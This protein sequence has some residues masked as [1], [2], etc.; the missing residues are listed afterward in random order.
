[1]HLGPENLIKNLIGLWTG[2]FK[3]L[4][5]GTG[6]YILPNSTVEAI[7]DECV[8]AGHTTPSAFGA[9]VPNLA[10]QLHYYTAESYT[11]FTTLLAPT[12]LRGRF[13][14]E[15]YYNHLLDLVPTFDDCMALSLDR[16]YVDKELRMRIVEWV[17]LYEK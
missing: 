7:G 8:R 3:G 14:K 6:G 12:L 5:E 9:R 13:R 11:L 4:D 10:T 16:E 15:K 1:M 17:Q 2:D